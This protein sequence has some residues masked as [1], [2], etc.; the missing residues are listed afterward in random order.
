VTDDCSNTTT[1]VVPLLVDEP[2]QVEVDGRGECF[3]ADSGA[4]GL[5]LTGAT[6]P[7]EL[8]V[9]SS[10]RSVVHPEDVTFEGT[11]DNRM[12]HVQADRGKA[13]LTIT[14]NDGTSAD[15][16]AVG[17]R[18]GT[19]QRDRVL[20]TANSDLLFGGRG[21]DTL[22]GREGNDV[23]CEG[24]GR[25][26]LTGGEGADLFSGGSGTDKATDLTVAHGDEQDGTIP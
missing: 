10:D 26:R 7:V 24:P 12:M 2:L 1:K 3:D 9:K 14:A 22:A 16:V 5:T 8:S 13:V 18:V 25:G 11:G 4:I 23:L 20:G 15:T 19:R 21:N 6:G 17:V